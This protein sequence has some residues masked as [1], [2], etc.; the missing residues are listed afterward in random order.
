MRESCHLVDRDS[1]AI[2]VL[3]EKRTT[4]GADDVRDLVSQSSVIGQIGPVLEETL[5]TVV[6]VGANGQHAAV[7]AAQFP[8]TFAPTSCFMLNVTRRM[9]GAAANAEA[10]AC[11]GC[12]F[13]A[14]VR[15]NRLEFHSNQPSQI[16]LRTA[17]LCA[18]S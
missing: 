18:G 11:P 8:V 14:W 10:L 1:T 12:S 15:E 6:T 3:I 4:L 9:L 16:V 5:A 2:N 13:A 17:I 7:I